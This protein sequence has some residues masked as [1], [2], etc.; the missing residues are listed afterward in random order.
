MNPLLVILGT[1]PE[2]IKCAPVI[3]EA[4][5]RGWVVDIVNTGQH[6]RLFADTGFELEFPEGEALGTPN[7]GDPIA[8][9]EAALERLHQWAY[10]KGPHIV[11]VQGDTASAD[12]GGR[13]AHAL[14]WPLVHLEAGL[15]TGDLTDPWPEE[16]IRRTIDCRATLRLAPT[17]LALKALIDEGLE[18]GSVL[19]GNTVVDAMRYLQ[20]RHVP[21]P[22]RAPVV[23]VTLHR[24][25]S[26]GAPLEAIVEGIKAVALETE[27]RH[28]L[29]FRWPAHLAP[30][31]QE[32]AQRLKEWTRK[33]KTAANFRV[34]EP[35]PYPRFVRTLA[36]ARAVVTDSGGVVEEAATL[37]VPCVIT[38]D[39]TER[40]EAVHAGAAILAGRTSEGVASALRQ[41]LSG[42]IPSRPSSVFGD[43]HAA[44]QSCD[45]IERAFG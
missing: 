14:G 32:A 33:W 10:D 25:E 29:T 31:V 34:E 40:M 26:W 2:A 30:A 17:P 21:M 13:M 42:E 23:I 15:R 6:H 38:R 22:I 19:V 4:R 8:F 41:C 20:L 5:R 27:N 36:Y 9:A 44:V 16:G 35:W 18:R 12:A 43:G 45:A 24:R 37:G 39:K 3:R 28:G 7:L 11:L 1:R